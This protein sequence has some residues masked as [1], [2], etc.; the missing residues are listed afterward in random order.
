MRGQR[1]IMK[2]A[3]TFDVDGEGAGCGYQ[4]MVD[5]YILSLLDVD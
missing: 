5:A 3:Y 1:I 2:D 4:K